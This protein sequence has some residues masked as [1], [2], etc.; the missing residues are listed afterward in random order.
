MTGAFYKRLYYF[1]ASLCR[2][3]GFLATLIAYIIV[4][5]VVKPGIVWLNVLLLYLSIA[6]LISGLLLLLMCGMSVRNYKYNKFRQV[7]VLIITILT[8]GVLGIVF[9]CI[10]LGTKITDEDMENES[11]TKTIG[12]KK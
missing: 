5:I 8:G 9:S 2:L 3:I 4:K 12:D 1:F 7:V 11:I 10:A 6:G